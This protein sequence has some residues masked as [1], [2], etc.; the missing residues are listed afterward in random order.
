MS[1]GSCIQSISFGNEI[2]N[3]SRKSKPNVIF[4]L[5]DD[6]GWGDLGVFYQNESKRE[7]KFK[8][9]Y[10][11]QMAAEGLQMRAHYCPAPV[12]APSRASLLT[13]V[14]QGHATIRDNQFD[15]MLV[16]NHTLA[17]VM[18]KAGYRTALIGKYGLQGK[19]NNPK[20]WPGYPTK[21]G[22]DEFFGYVAHRDGHVHYPADRW[23]IGN[24]ESHR[25]GKDLWWNDKEVSDDMQKCYTTD[26]FTA[27]SK[28]WIADHHKSNPDQPFFLYLAYDTP[29]GALQVPT[30]PYPEGAGVDGGIQWTG[31]PGQMINTA[32]GKIDSFRHPDYADKDWTDVEVRFATMVRRIDSAVGDLLQTLTDLGIAENT[33][34]VFTSDNGPHHESYIA[35]VNYEAKSFRSFGPFDGTKRDTWEGGIRMPTLAWWPETIEPGRI[36]HSPS[37]FHDWMPTMAEAGG[38]AT[39]ARSDG[40]SLM[41]TLT[42][43]GEQQTSTIYVEYKVG[44]KTKPYPSFQKSRRG[45]K[46]GQMQV[47]HVDRYKG[48]R[49]DIRSHEDPFEIYDVA[50]D[51]RERRNLAEEKTDAERD[52]KRGLSKTQLDQLQRR[53]RD[54]VLRLRVANPSAR[55]PYD[56]ELVPSLDVSKWDERQLENS[57]KIQWRAVQGEFSFVPNLNLKKA[58]SK[59]AAD[60]S[61][62]R[63]AGPGAVEFSTYLKVEKSGPVV[64]RF[65]CPTKGFVR[66]HQAGVIDADYGYTSGEERR[67]TI[68]L[69]QGL[70]PV[71][72]TVLTDSNGKAAF[73]FVSK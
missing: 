31:K 16:D 68:N 26:L 70:H 37:Q 43:R 4:I 12:C 2:A 61:M 13:G 1:S 56:N 44:G 59:G 25:S 66:I 42:G 45:K 40:V 48:I 62:T 5:T 51:P 15:K 32:K 20:T 30:C 73:D 21:R 35:N 50:I 19:G 10:L 47:V 53:M 27:R 63:I 33:L 52:E 9:P 23:E 11:D 71:R 49:T 18:K 22:F 38:I 57:S 34:V 55:R 6:L 41:P 65:Q 46:R 58:D 36:I 72:I 67:A 64:L 3:V 8:T 28:Q 54:K 17:T 60:V 69:E 14:H 24:S 7:R 39:P 29:H